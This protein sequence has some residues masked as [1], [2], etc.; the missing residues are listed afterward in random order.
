MKKINIKLNY[1]SYS[2]FLKYNIFDEIIYYH[3]KKF[4]NCKAIIITDKNVK[5]YYLKKLIQKFLMKEIKIEYYT[6]LPGEQSKSFDT[7]EV[8]T[9]KILTKGVNR[10]DIIYAL[11][12]GVVGDLSGFLSSILLRGI[13]FIQIPTTLLSQVDSSVGGKTGINTKIGKNLVGSFFQPT[14]VFIDPQTL[15]TLSKKDFLAGYSEVVKYSLINDRNFFYWLDK[16]LKGTYDLLPEN[17]LKIISTCV[18]K[19]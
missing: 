2:I 15:Y 13:K 4:K 16:N 10:N 14:A 8:L 19:S 9:N 7:L 12:G 3:L 1:H 17:I 5:K 6:V 11:G 18:R